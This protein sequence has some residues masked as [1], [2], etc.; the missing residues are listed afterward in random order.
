M[1]VLF[2]SKAKNSFPQDLK[3][4]YKL[5]DQDFENMTSFEIIELIGKKRGMII[6]GG[7]IDTLRVSKMVIEEFRSGKIGKIMIEKPQD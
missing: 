3:I 6:S 2:A 7:E 5:E 1:A 4:R